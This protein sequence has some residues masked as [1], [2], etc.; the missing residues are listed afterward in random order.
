MVI[1][2]IAAALMCGVLAPLWAAAGKDTQ[3]HMEAAKA[4]IEQAQ[5]ELEQASGEHGGH[6]AKA[7]EHLKA[8][9]SEVQAGIYYAN[10]EEKQ[11][12]GAKKKPGAAKGNGD[13]MQ[14]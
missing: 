11:E 2:C 4:A 9:L 13:N 1:F 7:L 5:K 12:Q 6:R 8:A 14:H 3:P 10:H